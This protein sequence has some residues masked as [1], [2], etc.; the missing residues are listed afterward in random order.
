MIIL[1][2]VVFFI[3]INLLASDFPDIFG[4]FCEGGVILGKIKKDDSIKIGN[5]KLDIF[6]VIKNKYVG[7]FYN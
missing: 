4:C 7:K 5:K 6:I 2:W 3:P 1:F